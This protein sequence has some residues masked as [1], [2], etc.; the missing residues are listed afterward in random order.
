MM[1]IARRSTAITNT[2]NE[3]LTLESGSGQRLPKRRKQRSKTEKVKTI[4]VG[5]SGRL[6]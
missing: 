1:Y 2:K 4:D 6:K 5:H 3:E